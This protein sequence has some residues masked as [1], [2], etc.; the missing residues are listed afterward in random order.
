MT[1]NM[2]S[3][4]DKRFEGRELDDITDYI[5]KKYHGNLWIELPKLITSFSAIVDVHSPDYDILNEIKELVISLKDKLEKHLELE[6]K[7]QYP[8][9]NRYV[10]TNSNED[11][12]IA[13]DMIEELEED[14]TIIKGTLEEIRQ[15]AKNYFEVQCGCPAY[16]SAF[17]NLQ[18]FEANILELIELKED[19]LFP[20]LKELKL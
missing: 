9:I 19:I 17:D 1:Q 10:K 13:V 15:K 2:D 5:V 18:D 4:W 16:N 6:E 12:K 14:H 7:V 3:I 20:R 8:A 11:L